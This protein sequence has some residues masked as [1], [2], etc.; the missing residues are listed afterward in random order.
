MIIIFY[1]LRCSCT[2]EL[3]NIKIFESY[4]NVR[5]FSLYWVHVFR[6]KV[7]LTSDTF[8]DPSIKEDDHSPPSGV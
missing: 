1:G 7:L 2:N 3:S 5:L 8:V 6:R 4:S